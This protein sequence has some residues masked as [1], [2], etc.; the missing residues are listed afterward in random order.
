[1][2][3]CQLE[4]VLL[5][6]QRLAAGQHIQVNAQ[7]FALRNDLI[8]ILKAE[9]ILVAVLAGPAAHAVHI[10]GRGGVEQNQ[11]RDVALVLDAVFANHFSA[12]EEGFVAQIQRGGTCHM[13][14]GLIQHTI[15]E[16]R[17]L[18]VGVGQDL[19]CIL[20]GLIAVGVAV[21]LLCN[22]HQLTHR[23]FTVVLGAGKHHVHHF[24][25]SRTLHLVGQ[26]IKRCIHSFFLPK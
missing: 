22:I 5:A 2:L 12:A 18:A 19:F 1:M 17:P 3:F 25:K 16:L 10:A 23:F 11:P 20:V 26:I 13:G 21:E 24:T 6:H 9:V 7:L 15:D 8:H 4:H 14:V